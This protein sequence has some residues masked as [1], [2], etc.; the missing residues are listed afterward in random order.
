MPRLTLKTRFEQGI[1]PGKASSAI[2]G[3]VGNFND[4][5]RVHKQ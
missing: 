3:Q 4:V 2:G 5:C 1:S